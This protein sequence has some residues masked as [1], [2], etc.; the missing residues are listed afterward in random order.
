MS[1]LFLN[2]L[3]VNNFRAFRNLKIEKLGRVNLIVGR[4]NIGKTSL[5]EVLR[6][7]AKRGAPEV[8]F[9]ILNSRDE[10]KLPTSSDVSDLESQSLNL[11]YLFYGRSELRRPGDLFQI[12]PLNTPPETMIFIASW[13]KQVE[14]DQSIRFIPIAQEEYDLVEQPVLTVAIQMGKQKAVVRRAETYVGQRR[15]P[16]PLSADINEVPVIYI[17]ASGLDKAQI[18]TWRDK[19]LVEGH[20]KFILLALQLIEPKIIDIDFIGDPQGGQR[21]R[22]PVARLQGQ[23]KFIPL[24]SLG[25]GINRLFAIALGLTNAPNGLL[26]IDEVENGLHYATQINLWRIIMQIARELNIQVFATTH[27]SDC[28]EAFNVATKEMI[29]EEGVLIR[30]GRKGD[31]IVSTLFD[32]DELQIANEQAI[33]VR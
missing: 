19:A 18:A 7:Y 11:R 6:L 23:E 30:L 32:E 26:L 2:S 9:D 31:T 25:E 4:N 8:V 13:Q 17:P 27:S 33:E 12:G 28:I 15:R 21:E 29:E 16:S 10:N 14:D 1:K 20:Q 3:E 24:R 22:I 5:L